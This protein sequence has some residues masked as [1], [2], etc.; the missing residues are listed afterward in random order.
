MSVSIPAPPSRI[1]LPVFPVIT[2]FSAFPVPLMLSVPVKVKFSTFA[3]AARL[4]VILALIVSFPSL[5]FSVMI[6]VVVSTM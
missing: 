5:A 2:L 1:L 4:N 6:S 3:I